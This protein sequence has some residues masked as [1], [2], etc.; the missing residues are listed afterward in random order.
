MA[1]N[2][3]ALLLEKHGVEYSVRHESNWLGN[4]LGW[5]VPFALL[6]LL[7]SWMG[8]RMSGAGGFLNVGNRVRIHPDTLP[9]VT[10]DDV[11]GADEAKEELRESIEFASSS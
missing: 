1:D 3:L 7:W 5:I 6:L 10:F 4:L 8:R 9:K 11:A 2:E